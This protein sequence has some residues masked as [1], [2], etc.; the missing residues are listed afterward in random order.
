MCACFTLL[1]ARILHALI[2]L[3]LH[4]HMYMCVT[5][6]PPPPPLFRQYFEAGRRVHALYPQTTCFYPAVVHDLPR[7]VC[8]GVPLPPTAPAS[9]IPRVIIST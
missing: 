5:L 6:P 3:D 1:G 7:P 8:E 4:M 9:F 2:I